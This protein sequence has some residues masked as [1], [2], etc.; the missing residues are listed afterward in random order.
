[1]L[2]RVSTRVLTPPAVPDPLKLHAQNT[3]RQGA[4]TFDAP[5][6]AALIS[7]AAEV[8][9]WT[10]RLW[11]LAESDG[12]RVIQTV[13]DVPT[14]LH[15]IRAELTP[16][17]PAVWQDISATV[18]EVWK[19][20]AW[21]AAD[22]DAWSMPVPQTVRF[23]RGGQYRVRASMTVAPPVPPEVEEGVARLWAA[24]DTLRPGDKSETGEY[25][26]LQ[27]AMLKSGAAEI[28][29]GVREICR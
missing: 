21:T 28:L 9:R 10:G 26:A 18:V 17:Y 24:R 12:A 5:K 1:M 29:R 23:V 4:V 6:L 27:G 14:L 15:G 19:S 16:R 3:S 7:C 20:G 25:H 8:E 22:S 11:W 2:H 13:W